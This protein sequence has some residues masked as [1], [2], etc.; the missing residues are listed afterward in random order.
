MSGLDDETA[1]VER[2]LVKAQDGVVARSKAQNE[3]TLAETKKLH[4]PKTTT[5]SSARQ[6]LASSRPSCRA[7]VARLKRLRVKMTRERTSTAL[8]P[9]FTHELDLIK[10]IDEPTLVPAEGWTTRLA[11]PGVESRSGVGS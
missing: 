10:R 2:R 1:S 8:D 4:V 6:H 11:T 5:V 7:S 9:D 3:V